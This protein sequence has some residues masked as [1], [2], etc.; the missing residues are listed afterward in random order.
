MEDFLGGRFDWVRS[1]PIGA[2]AA[3]P[4][5]LAP[6]REEGA[7]EPCGVVAPDCAP[8][9]PRTVADLRPAAAPPPAA[10]VALLLSGGGRGGNGAFSR[11]G[12][13]VNLAAIGFG[14]S[15]AEEAAAL[16]S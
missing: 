6:L 12:G 1:Q 10:G 9:P 5:T 4:A 2:A 13:T 14:A 16:D 15:W 11:T 8:R 3:G 7:A